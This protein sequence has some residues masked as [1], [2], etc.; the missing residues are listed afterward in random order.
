MTKIKKLFSEIKEI[1]KN[2]IDM[3]QKGDKI[4]KD[5]YIAIIFSLIMTII[6]LIPFFL[7]RCLKHEIDHFFV[8]SCIYLACLFF[9][10]SICSGMYLFYKYNKIK[11]LVKFK[12]PFFSI[13]IIL[14]LL[15][16]IISSPIIFVLR[17]IEFLSSFQAK[18]PKRFCLGIINIVAIFII[19]TIFLRLL[20]CILSKPYIECLFTSIEKYIDHKYNIFFI[21]LVVI[22]AIIDFFTSIVY[23]KCYLPIQFKFI[24]GDIK[25]NIDKI[26]YDKIYFSNIL[27]KFKV[28]ALLV[29]FFLIAAKILPD[30]YKFES[31]IINAIT[32]ATLVILVKDK[33]K[34]FKNKLE[35]DTSD[36]KIDN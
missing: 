5:Y 33:N 19:Y 13:F 22:F 6:L 28:S 21:E 24:Y 18:T 10:A 8:K 27:G 31:Q 3:W 17:I 2:A 23:K 9:F 32:L 25:K 29:I 12:I 1:I 20:I 11:C 4:N 34:E 14:F 26:N 35:K 30:F 16:V 7:V 36:T 15:T